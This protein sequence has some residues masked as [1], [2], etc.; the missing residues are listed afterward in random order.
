M[1]AY[2]AQPGSQRGRKKS[3]DGK[4]C[5]SNFCSNSA[6][7]VYVFGI[8]CVMFTIWHSSGA[9]NWWICSGQALFNQF[10]CVCVCIRLYVL[11]YLCKAEIAD[12]HTEK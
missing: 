6:V 1:V 12:C 3:I 2:I 7:C 9:V 5:R 10:V 8:S 11:G 4:I